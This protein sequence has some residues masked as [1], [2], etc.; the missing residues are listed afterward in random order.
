MLG[1]VIN[2]AT[3]IPL[4]L[5]VLVALF[6]IGVIIKLVRTLDRVEARLTAIEKRL[7]DDA[8]NFWTVQDQEIFTLRMGKDNPSL[9]IPECR[10]ADIKNVA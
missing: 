4:G 10:K 9:S 6:V 5:A 3:Y 1:Q 2:E 8:K 7:D